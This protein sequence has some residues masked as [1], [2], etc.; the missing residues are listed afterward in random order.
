[1]MYLKMLSLLTTIDTFFAK[2]KACNTN[3][4]YN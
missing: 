3:I 4:N 2:M 1:M